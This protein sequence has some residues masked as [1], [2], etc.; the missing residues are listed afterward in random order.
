MKLHIGCGARDFGPEWVHI[1]GADYP[2]VSFHDITKLDFPDDTVDLIYASHVIEYFDREE[3]IPILQE[4]KRVLKTGGILR[5]A[6]PDFT[7]MTALYVTGEPLKSFLGPLYGKMQ[8]GD[9]TIYHKT[10]YD[11]PSLAL[12]IL[13]SGFK[14]ARK[15]DWQ[16]TDHAGFDDHSQAH[17]PHMDKKKGT[18]ISLNIE[19]IK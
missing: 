1:D 2:H 13:N 18:L 4:W 17:I 19:C 8:M 10:V 12:L 7:A 3:I 14:S 5:I 16:Q 9:K 11:F 6:V 15:Y